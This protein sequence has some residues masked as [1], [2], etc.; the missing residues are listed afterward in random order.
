[1]LPAD[2]TDVLERRY[3]RVMGVPVSAEV[4]LVRFRSVAVLVSSSPAALR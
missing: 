1:V 3:E 4:E 2:V